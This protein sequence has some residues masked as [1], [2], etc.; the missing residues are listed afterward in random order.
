DAG[1]VD[2]AV[3]DAGVTEVEAAAG[4]CSLAAGDFSEH[5]ASAAEA[6]RADMKTTLERI[7]MGRLV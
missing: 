6:A 5:A 1:A 4:C 2:A 3:V 7:V